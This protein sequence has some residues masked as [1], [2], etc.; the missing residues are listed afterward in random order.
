MMATGCSTS[1]SNGLQVEAAWDSPFEAP[2]AEQESVGSLG[3]HLVD[4]GDGVIRVCD[5]MGVYPPD[6][7]IALKTGRGLRVS[8]LLD[9]IKKL[10]DKSADVIDLKYHHQLA[11]FV[12]IRIALNTHT[13]VVFCL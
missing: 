5:E 3:G 11:V 2:A 6:P 12:N 13:V 9:E 10:K 7:Q 1:K 8:D 4:V